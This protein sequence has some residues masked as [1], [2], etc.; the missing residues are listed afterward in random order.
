MDRAIIKVKR[1]SPLFP[2]LFLC[3]LPAPAIAQQTNTETQAKQNIQVTWAR[4]ATAKVAAAKALGLSAEANEQY[5]LAIIAW[6]AAGEIDDLSESVSAARNRAAQF[7]EEAEEG[8]KSASEYRLRLATRYLDSTYVWVRC[9][10]PSGDTRLASLYRE[11]AQNYR[12]LT[13]EKQQDA[14]ITE[15]NMMKA[16]A[17]AYGR[18]A[19]LWSR[20]A[21]AE[22]VLHTKQLEAATAWEQVAEATERAGEA[23]EQVVEACE[24]MVEGERLRRQGLSSD[25]F[26]HFRI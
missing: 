4:T 19:D 12:S 23:H 13:L 24:R 26:R 5:I 21:R 18:Y 6:N 10:S 14:A 25:A 7:R 8:R 22:E 2:I 11:Q 1:Y 16:Q 9:K 20:A 15:G 3:I 17:N